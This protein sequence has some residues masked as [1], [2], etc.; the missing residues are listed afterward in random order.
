MA[1]LVSDINTDVRGILN[2]ST[3]NILTESFLLPLIN[4]AYR[5]AQSKA[6]LYGLSYIKEALGLVPV[7]ATD[8][9]ITVADLISP[10]ELSERA[11]GA[12]TSYEPMTQLDWE[13][14]TTKTEKLRYWNWRENEI[15]IIGATQNRE[16]RIKYNKGLPA[17]TGNASVLALTDVRPWLANRVAA[18]SAFSLGASE[19]GLAIMEDS[20]DLYDTF[21]ANAVKESQILGVRKKPFRRRNFVSYVR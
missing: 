19:R 21:I 14:D 2:D 9:V 8:T 6:R 10:I 18:L 4:K 13:P 3:G 5:E 1:D 20:K 17:L 12:T 7:L 16:V 15:K 11:P